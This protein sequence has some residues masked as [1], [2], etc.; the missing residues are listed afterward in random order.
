MKLQNVYHAL[1]VFV[2][3]IEDG[4]YD[5][6]SLP[7]ATKSHLC[8]ED[9]QKLQ[10]LKEQAYSGIHTSITHIYTLCR[11][12]VVIRNYL[13]SFASGT[14]MELLRDLK[15]V[16]VLLNQIEPNIVK[17]VSTDPQVT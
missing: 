10:Q 2:Q 4:Y 11:R 1:Q 8:E 16:T 5:F 7:Y 14:P 6:Q 13:N 9:E 3:W 17:I 15:H 12:T